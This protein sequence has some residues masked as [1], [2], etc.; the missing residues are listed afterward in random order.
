MWLFYVLAPPSGCT[1]WLYYV[2]AP[3]S[4]YTFLQFWMECGWIRPAV[5]NHQAVV[6]L[7]LEHPLVG[8]FLWSHLKG[9]ITYYEGPPTDIM[10][11]M[12]CTR[13][14]GY[15]SG[16]VSGISLGRDPPP[17]PPPMYNFP[18]SFLH[19]FLVPELLPSI[20]VNVLRG[21]GCTMRPLRWCHYADM[22]GEGGVWHILG[23]AIFCCLPPKL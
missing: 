17:P 9:W 15:S 4:G 19:T 2:L 6:T 14:I 10:G 8:L 12:I 7:R 18:S 1:M 20:F 3:P 22:Q 5:V 11:G 23:G 13:W 16:A 21:G